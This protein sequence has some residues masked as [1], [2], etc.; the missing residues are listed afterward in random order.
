[1]ESSDAIVGDQGRGEVALRSVSACHR[2]KFGRFITVREN[3]LEPQEVCETPHRD[4]LRPLV[5]PKSGRIAVKVF[6]V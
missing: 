1:V 2:Y 6:K 5:K 3:G 4:S